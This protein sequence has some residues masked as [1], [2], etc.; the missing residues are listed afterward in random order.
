MRS[1]GL[2]VPCS[3]PSSIGNLRDVQSGKKCGV[4][5]QACL[6]HHAVLTRPLLFCHDEAAEHSLYLA[7]LGGGGVWSSL[8]TDTL[9]KNFSSSSVLIVGLSKEDSWWKLAFSCA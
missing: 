4:R 7:A 5:E 8:G 9:K 1:A 3:P 6:L 2:H